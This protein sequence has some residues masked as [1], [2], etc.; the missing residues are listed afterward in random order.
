MA[1]DDDN[2]DRNGDDGTTAES[3]TRNVLLACSSGTKEE[4]LELIRRHDDDDKA[5]IV[6]RQCPASGT[7]P[8]MAAAAAGRLDVCRTLIERGAP[9]NA[10][11]RS[12]KCAGNHASDAG[13]QDV[14]DFLVDAAVTAELV[15]GA[16][17]R[18]TKTKTTTTSSSSSSSNNVSEAPSTKPDYLT[19]HR[20]RYDDGGDRTA[21]LDHDGDAVMMEWERPLMRAHASIVTSDF[22]AGK[23]VLNVG[24]GMGIVDGFLQE[25]RPASHV[26]VEAHPDVRA[27]AVA[28]GW[29][30]KPNVRLLFGRWQD[31]LPKLVAEAENENNDDVLFDG[32]FFDTYGEHY[33][34]ME[35]FH[36]IVAKLL[37]KPD[38]VYSFFNGLA[39]DNIFF[40]GVACQCVKLQLA[41]LGL[42]TEFAPCEIKVDESAWKGVRRKY[43]HMDTYYLPI[44]TWKKEH[45]DKTDTK[46]EDSVGVQEGTT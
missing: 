23:R 16:S 6:C 26:I 14:V 27:N 11:D 22:A 36:E 41:K 15:L 5:P 9:W 1:E 45:V 12:G 31:V 8:L 38:G 40:H 21:L 30:D 44:C 4:I 28:A 3:A 32:I 39:P 37:R 20:V 2:N 19:S 17:A 46:T 33:S 10:V 34:D 42:D 29:D 13:H 24:F 7:S 43:W 18:A 35:D 25:S